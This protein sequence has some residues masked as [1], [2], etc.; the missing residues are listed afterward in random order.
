MLNIIRLR[1][2]CRFKTTVFCHHTVTGMAEVAKQLKIPI[3]PNAE[4]DAQKLEISHA[5]G[6]NANTVQSLWKRV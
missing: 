1:G 3:I 6:E 4:E 5:A 2:K